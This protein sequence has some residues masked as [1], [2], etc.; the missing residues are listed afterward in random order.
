MQYQR[1]RMA[2][3]GNLLGYVDGAMCPDGAHGP[4]GF[5]FE[6]PAGPDEFWVGCHRCRLSSMP[7]A[8]LDEAVADWNE[9]V[10]QIKAEEP[11]T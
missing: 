1:N 9:M 6:F 8:T 3:K 10:R 7:M 2:T 11:K 5:H 4:Q